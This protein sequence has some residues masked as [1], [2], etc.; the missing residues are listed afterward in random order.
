[1]FGR[2]EIVDYLFESMRRAHQNVTFDRL[3]RQ[4]GGRGTEA[5]SIPNPVWQLTG[6]VRARSAG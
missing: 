6:S 1:L 5:N 3:R 2:A 4:P